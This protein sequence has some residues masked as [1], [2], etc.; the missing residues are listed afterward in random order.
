M[1]D[2]ENGAIDWNSISPYDIAK[3]EILRGP[4]S[5]LYGD[6]GL[7]GV[8]NVTTKEEKV[9]TG[10]AS[11]SAGSFGGRELNLRTSGKVQD[12]PY[13]LSFQSSATDGFR[14]HSGWGNSTLSG[15]VTTSLNANSKLQWSFSN[16]TT[17]FDDPGPLTPADLLNDREG[18]NINYGSDGKIE[19]RFN[20]R[21][22]Y[23]T[24]LFERADFR[25]GFYTQ[26][27]TANTIGTIPLLDTA[28][29]IFYNTKER[30]VQSGVFGIDATAIVEDTIEDI[31]NK[32]IFGLELETGKLQSTYFTYDGLT[33]SRTGWSSY[34]VGKRHHVGMF[35]H[36]EVP[37][38]PKVKL[39]GG[40]RFDSY[41]DSYDVNSAS[42]SHTSVTPKVGANYL[43]ATELEN[44]IPV[45]T[46]NVY[47]N[48]SR[49]FKA[50]TLDQ[51]FDQR[52]PI[53]NPKLKPQN[54][55]NLEAGV[56]QRGRIIEKKMYGEMVT[57]FYFIPMT[58]EIDYDVATSKYANITNSQHL[59]IENGFKLHW[60]PNIT[61]F[62]NYTFTSVTFSSGTF[63]GNQLK[64]IPRHSL[65]FGATYRHRTNVSGTLTWN[66]TGDRYYD[67]KNSES[68]SGFHTLNM[69]ISYKRDFLRGFVDFENILGAK[70]NSFGYEFGGTKFAYSSAP[71]S[72][73]LGV[74]ATFDTPWFSK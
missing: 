53:S 24:T 49:A 57:S 5:A 68:L 13:R 34:G 29:T 35:V 73:R 7:G 61:A 8:I 18:T 52:L 60:V 16:R 44:D 54:G 15:D 43:F 62:L 41:N 65:A 21:V 37:I 42:A 51:L 55:W 66:Y 17:N 25:A 20:G 1:N 9:S 72:I 33:D 28:L 4:A 46:G 40:F 69:R 45:Y 10:V 27:R 56:Y 47:G 22:N 23:S 26:Q 74:E 31:P 71:T 58:D 12:V 2:L 63:S 70:F 36:D 38:T 39:N 19:N 3:M 67:D 48:I 32:F 30:E 11:M 14:K 6:V 50:P 59:G 64:G